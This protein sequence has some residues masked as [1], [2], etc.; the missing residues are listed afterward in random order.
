MAQSFTVK[1]QNYAARLATFG[2]ALMAMCDAGIPL[3]QEFADETYG[4]GGA[5]AITDATIQ[6][7]YPAITAAQFASAEGAIVAIL[8]T[9]T[10]NRGFMQVFKP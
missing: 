1:Q 9:Y 6:A 4:T 8:A 5:N 7:L 3:T 10:S 2:V